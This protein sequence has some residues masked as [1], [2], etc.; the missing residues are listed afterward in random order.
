MVIPSITTQ[1]QPFMHRAPSPLEVKLSLF[2]TGS[3]V[4]V[5][6]GTS[7]AAIVQL[8]LIDSQNHHRWYAT[9]GMPTSVLIQHNPLSL[10]GTLFVSFFGHFIPTE[11]TS[12]A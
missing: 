8:I 11:T 3:S 9:V 4:E 1:L 10:N 12:V 6:V 5:C 7:S 2:I